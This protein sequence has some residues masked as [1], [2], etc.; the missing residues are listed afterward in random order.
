MQH[1]TIPGR[2]VTLDGGFH[3]LAR[4][5]QRDD[6]LAPRSFRSLFHQH[7]VTIED[8]G[9]DHRIPLDPQSEISATPFQLRQAAF[10]I[11]QGKNRNSCGNPTEDGDAGF[12]SRGWSFW[13]QETDRTRIP[14]QFDITFSLQRPK[15]KVGGLC[16]D[17]KLR[18]QL[19]TRWRT[20]LS[21]KYPLQDLQHRALTRTQ[22]R[23]AISS[24]R[25]CHEIPLYDKYQIVQASSLTAQFTP[26]SATI[27]RMRTPFRLVFLTFL[28]ACTN[29][30]ASDAP[31]ASS[32]GPSVTLREASFRPGETTTEQGA[33]APQEPQAQE[34]LP[35]PTEEDAY[36][37]ASHFDAP[38]ALRLY[39]Y[40][41]REK[42]EELTAAQNP[43][44]PKDPENP[45]GPKVAPDPVRIALLKA[46]LEWLAVSFEDTAEGSGNQTMIRSMIATLPLTP[47]HGMA[48]SLLQWGHPD[49]NARRGQ[50]T[51]WQF[52]GPFDNERG[53]AMDTALA[54]ESSPAS[55]EAFP[56]KVRPVQ[57]RTTPPSIPDNGILDFSDL[58]RPSEQS[59]LLLR[60]WVESSSTQDVTLLLGIEGE[61]RVWHD[62]TPILDAPEYREYHADNLAA[63]LTLHPGWNEIAVKLGSRDHAPQLSARL[64]DRD[65]R[66]LRMAV[67]AKPPEEVLPQMLSSEAAP[68]TPSSA[69]PGALAYYHATTLVAPEDAQ[70]HYRLGFLENFYRVA[71]KADFPGRAA[72]RRATELEPEDLRYRFLYALSLFPADAL[73]AEVDLNPWLEQAQLVLER[74]P[75]HPLMNGLRLQAAMQ[76]QHIEPVALAA[77]DRLFQ[78]CDGRPLTLALRGEVHNALG[79]ESLAERDARALLAHP[80]A[81]HFPGLTFEAANRVL[82]S[83]S[84]RL[85]PLLQ[86]LYE[87][88]PTIEILRSLVYEQRLQRATFDPE[89]EFLEL[90]AMLVLDPWNSGLLRAS[91]E[92]FQSQGDLVTAFELVDRALALKPE[93]P[94]NLALQARLYLAAGNLEEAVATLEKELEIDYSAEDESRLLDHLRSLE[95]AS[96]EQPYREDLAAIVARHP[97]TS[98]EH[99]AADHS[100][101]HLLYRSVIRINPDSTADRYFR[102]VIRVLNPNGIRRLDV[103]S[104]PFSYGDEDLRVETVNVLHPDGTMETARTSR[105]WRGR[106]VDLPQLQVGDIVDLEWRVDDLRTT[107]FGKYF[108]LNHAMTPDRSVPTRES[109][110]VLLVPEQLPLKFHTLLM[111][112]SEAEVLETEDFGTSH[113]WTAFDLAPQRMESLMPPS[114]ETVARVQASSYATWEDFGAWWWNLI[115]AGIT[116]SPEM[117]DKVAELVEGKE[118]LREKVS[119]IYG[120][121]ANDI[122]YNAWEFGVHG[123]QPYTAPVIFSRQFGDCKDKGILI[124][125]M[126]SE[127]GV[128]AYPV[129]I[130]RTADGRHGGRRHEE[131]LSLAMVNHFNHCIAYIPAQQDLPAMF[132]DGT[133]RLHPLDV[134]PY[135][136]RG[137]QVLV[138]KPEGIERVRIPFSAATDNTKMQTFV[139]DYNAEGGAHVG[140]ILQ[141][142][143][144]FDPQYRNAFAGGDQDRKEVVEQI[145]T[146]LLGPLEGEVQYDIPDVEQ[147]ENDMVYILEGDA[148][149]L[150]RKVEGGLEI[151]FMLDRQG[152][153]Q[154][155]ASEADRTTDL[156]LDSPMVRDIDYEILLPDGWVL[157]VP[158]ETI[159]GATEDATYLWEIKA[160]DG[161]S[162]RV[163]ERFELLT[164]RI[165]L[166]RYDAFRELCRLVDSTQDRFFGATAPPPPDDSEKPMEASMDPEEK[167]T[168]QED[169]Q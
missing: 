69:R 115:D 53:A 9:L 68:E 148:S 11:F 137:A 42:L 95:G 130:L 99:D 101:E 163:H 39:T 159:R 81:M 120:F 127:I 125:A 85:I 21:G 6:D 124:R 67:T 75:T 154:G 43:T 46:E 72:A 74:Q 93:S 165:P 70:A 161:G 90:E 47:D 66:P 5:E 164:H 82:L 77:M 169:Q 112:G 121:V 97:E 58:V 4:A 51:T 129:L 86:D 150:A 65:A 31:T 14:T 24:R 23:K 94:A 78:A 113:S 110:L 98:A 166:E 126:L 79:Y 25:T 62:G 114:E 91:A 108:G 104:F 32:P 44:T 76:Y 135:D 131:D 116:V 123:Y 12:R 41:L 8:A 151:P 103:V 15:M 146:S 61:A 50:I 48:Y 122:R 60:T 87:V 133:A 118:T 160:L 144:R 106:R 19:L 168:L 59:A 128:E 49:R 147:L 16:T 158:P 119:A 96:F 89:Q 157:D 109:Q 102:K 142:S 162:F 80:E 57:W 28:G 36:A 111:P 92:R 3:F 84:P 18:P 143:G 107:F 22:G 71:P 37:L 139:A 10:L 83:G 73:A 64:V 88:S 38:G 155:L 136:D 13:G 30:V 54:P 153:L 40:L 138:V 34:A 1:D 26:P 33:R 105:G 167:A 149:G 45:K 141:P 55:A 7:Q 134:L 100:H 156:L 52:I 140:L 2:Q 17:S 117:R 56:G 27:K 152:L 132:V 145:L 35:P 63:P 29:G 20:L